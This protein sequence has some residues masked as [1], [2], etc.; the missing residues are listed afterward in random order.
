MRLSLCLLMVILAIC[1]YESNA[2]VCPSV[3]RT[4]FKYLFAP[5][6]ILKLHLLKYGAPSEASDAMVEAKGCTDQMSFPDRIRIK[7]ILLQIVKDC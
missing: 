5:K 6:P 1:C 4:S 2:A 7:K 3:L